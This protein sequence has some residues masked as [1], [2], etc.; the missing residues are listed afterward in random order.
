MHWCYFIYTIKIVSNSTIFNCSM[1]LFYA[2]RETANN[3]KTDT[4]THKT[5][6]SGRWLNIISVHN[7]RISP[8]GR[9]LLIAR[10]AD[11]NQ[12]FIWQNYKH[13]KNVKI[14]VPWYNEN[15]VQSPGLS[16]IYILSDVQSG[17]VLLP[18][19]NSD[20]SPLVVKYSQY[21]HES[22]I[23]TAYDYM[24]SSVLE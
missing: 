16:F 3:D 23:C 1:Y 14:I 17:A 15:P 10:L 2:S 4:D 6:M 20:I 13:E 9:Q 24:Q 7:F 18:N 12:L 11:W 22:N 8:E 19:I 5:L 21:L